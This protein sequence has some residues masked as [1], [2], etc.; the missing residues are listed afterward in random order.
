MNRLFDWLL[1]LPG[2]LVCL[3]RRHHKFSGC[4]FCET[5]FEFDLKR[6]KQDNDGFWHKVHSNMATALNDPNS[7]LR[8]HIASQ[9]TPEQQLAFSRAVEW[10]AAQKRKASSDARL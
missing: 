9:Q 5:C 7:D 10:L 3:V 4:L 2:R 1:F 6:L 8:R